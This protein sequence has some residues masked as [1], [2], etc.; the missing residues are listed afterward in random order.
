[1]TVVFKQIENLLALAFEWVP[2]AKRKIGAVKRSSQVSHYQEEPTCAG[3]IPPRSKLE[4]GMDHTFKP[5]SDILPAQV[6]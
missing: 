1:M 6:E 4:N 3:P 5:N 2:S